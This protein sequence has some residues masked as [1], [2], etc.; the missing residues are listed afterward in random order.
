MRKTIQ[1]LGPLFLGL[2][3]YCSAV[4][5]LL[6]HG[7]GMQ[8]VFGALYRMF[9][10][11]ERHPYQYIALF[12]AVFAVVLVWLLGAWPRTRRSPVWALTAWALLLSL[13]VASALGGGLWKL[14]D[15]QA[16]Y[17]P[18]G[19]RFWRD[20]WWG[21]EAGL[22]L[23]WRVLLASTPFQLLCLPAFY[24]ASRHAQRQYQA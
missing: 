6:K 22:L 21:V 19:E 9:L 3:L 12:C 8:M 7:L 14:H 18:Q 15:M 1:L 20:L 16:G 17:F 24:L 4:F 23:G 5:A 11:H 2:S 13:V 10:Y